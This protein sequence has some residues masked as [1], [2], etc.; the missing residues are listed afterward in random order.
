[1]AKSVIDAGGILDK[2]LGDGLMAIFGAM[3]DASDGAAA[4]TKAAMDMRAKLTTLNVDRERS[5]EPVIQFGIGVHTGEVVL[6]AVGLPERSDYTAIGDT[7]NTA[8]RMESLT[9]EFHVESVLSSE[10]AERLDGV[11][12][13]LR[14]LGEA[15]VRGKVAPLRIFTLK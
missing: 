5:G 6:G 13:A 11:G 1:M 14:P 12:G 3:G 7:V 4:A 2:F 8:S 15:V 10:T 9:K